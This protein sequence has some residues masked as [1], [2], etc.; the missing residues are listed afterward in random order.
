MSGLNE[1]IFLSA[2]S[3]LFLIPEGLQHPDI[4][5]RLRLPG[6]V[7]LQQRPQI[8][9]KRVSALR[10]SVEHPDALPTILHPAGVAQ[11]GQVSGDG[12]LGQ[13]QY[14]HEVAD[15]QLPVQKQR[16]DAEARFVGESFECLCGS[17]HGEI[18]SAQADEVNGK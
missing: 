4:F 15:A 7:F 3:R 16:K 14:C 8:Q 11:I 12:G 10:Q 17:F 13:A 2:F 5:F 9:N 1:E 18:V 6:K